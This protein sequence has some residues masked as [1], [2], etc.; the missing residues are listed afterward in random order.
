METFPTSKPEN[1]L[2]SPVEIPGQGILPGF[3]A[4]AVDPQPQIVELVG[5]DGYKFS[6]NLPV[7]NTPVITPEILPTE[8]ETPVTTTNE[9]QLVLLPAETLPTPSNVIELRPRTA[10]RV[11]KVATAAAATFVAVT[12]AKHG[13]PHETAHTH[14]DH[15]VLGGAAGMGLFGTRRLEQLAP[16]R[17]NRTG[18]QIN[19]MAI[20]RAK[21]NV[22][23]PV[24][25]SFGAFMQRDYL[26]R[27][28][29]RAK[30]AVVL[31]ERH[32]DKTRYSLDERDA[33]E[34]EVI[35]RD[36]WEPYNSSQQQLHD[37]NIRNKHVQNDIN[38]QLKKAAKVRRG[39]WE[40]WQDY[41]ANVK[42][43]KILKARAHARQFEDL[44]GNKISSHENFEEALQ[45]LTRR[46]DK[47]AL[48]RAYK[49]QHHADEA[50]SKIYA[51]LDDASKLHHKAPVPERIVGRAVKVARGAKQVITSPA[52]P[53]RSMKNNFRDNR[54]DFMD[55]NAKRL[56]IEAR[57]H[58]R[59]NTVA[60]T[61]DTRRSQEQL[62]KQAA[63]KR[64]KAS[65]IA[66]KVAARQTADYARRNPLTP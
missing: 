63:S 2:N 42:S 25:E 18:N 45:P 16:D 1:Q 36:A 19:L 23:T 50:N 27:P 11:A 9:N 43:W 26:N 53:L 54:T 49:Q 14:A 40:D 10:R 15:L 34:K 66:D 39:A 37:V 33:V 44:Y 61:P 41:R 35:Q 3:E 20:D 51:K 58:E 4:P 22:S 12:A 65:K 60:N 56:N 5:P 29:V 59:G 62:A 31:A 32:P 57:F 8:S 52:I 17:A 30:I 55:L 48:T 21:H 13:V 28:E 7:E 64:A 46:R 47:K 38:E 6:V 24:D